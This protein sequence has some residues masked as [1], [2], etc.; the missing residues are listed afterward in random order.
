MN[1]DKSVIPILVVLGPTASGK[2]AL[3]IALAK[4]LGGLAGGSRPCNANQI[5]HRVHSSFSPIACP[6]S[7]QKFRA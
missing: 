5:V 2:T 4:A 7:G 1:N 3:S 6:H